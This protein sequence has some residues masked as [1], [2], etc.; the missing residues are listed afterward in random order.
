[1]TVNVP[2]NVIAEVAKKEENL[3]YYVNLGRGGLKRANF[4]ET[5]YNPIFYDNYFVNLHSIPTG[6]LKL[7]ESIWKEEITH[8][9]LKTDDDETR[10]EAEKKNLKSFKAL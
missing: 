3:G 6:I 10:L 2:E 5:K 4:R 9:K 7:I 1:M 8:F